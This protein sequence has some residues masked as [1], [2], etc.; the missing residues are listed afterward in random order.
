MQHSGGIGGVSTL[1]G[2]FKPDL[3]GR[4]SGGFILG[5]AKTVNEEQKKGGA[6]GSQQKLPIKPPCHRRVSS[7]ARASTQFGSPEPPVCTFARVLAMG[8]RSEMAVENTFVFTGWRG[9]TGAAGG[10]I[11][12]LFQASS[13]FGACG[14]SSC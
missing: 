7:T 14:D 2:G 4:A 9:I 10:I 1:L 6:R 12:D 3:L 8:D 11:G 13:N 5:R